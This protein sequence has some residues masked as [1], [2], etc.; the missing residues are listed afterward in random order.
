MLL[1]E[2]QQ[3]ESIVLNGQTFAAVPN[4]KMVVGEIQ[5]ITIDQPDHGIL[6]TKSNRKGKGKAKTKNMVFPD[7][8]LTKGKKQKDEKS[9]ILPKCLESFESCVE[10]LSN[11]PKDDGVEG[12]E[13]GRHY[14]YL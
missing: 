4:L 7:Q 1:S 8:K 14:L 5:P 2:I 13:L 11:L 10:D 12:R 9:F 3:Q 6:G